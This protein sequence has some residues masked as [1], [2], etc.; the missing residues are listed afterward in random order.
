MVSDARRQP[1]TDSLPEAPKNDLDFHRMF[2]D[3]ESCRR[4]LE[5]LRWPKGFT[6]SEC[7]AVGEPIRITTRPGVLKCRSCYHIARVTAGTV[8]HRSKTSIRAWFW[9][10]YLV[11]TQTPGVSALELQ[12]KLGILRYETAFQLLHKL[13]DAMVRPGRDK[14]GAEW[15]L[16]LDIIFVGGKTRSGVQGVTNQ[17]PVILAVEIRRREVRDQRNKKIIERGIA[18]R[19]RIQMLPNKMANSVDKFVKNNIA[20]GAVI[21]SD[22]GSEF[23]NLIAL[24]FK[25]RPVAMRG[26]RAKM[27]SHLPMTGRI[28]ANLKIWIDGT[29]HG[30]LKK[31]LQAYLN[32]FTFRFNR[33]FYR[34][35]SFRTLL[36]L[37]TLHTGPTYKQVYNAISG[38]ISDESSLGAAT[39]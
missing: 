20:P 6:C 24:G 14:I 28:T 32:E 29:F 8:M 7:A 22:D 10:A 21:V 23:T 38:K 37:G 9:A 34:S 3:D 26:D 4:Y 5:R 2:P 36:G 17:V 1:D 27:D 35:S 12:K 39:V 18:G 15:P 19:I 31:H 16:E 11:A 25:H 30:V 33:R 13:R